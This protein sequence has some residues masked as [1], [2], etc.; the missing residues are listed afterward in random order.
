M[1][2]NTHKSREFQEQH[3]V[4]ALN[5]AGPLV[6]TTFEGL[7]TQTCAGLIAALRALAVGSSYGATIH[8]ADREF[9]IKNLIEE[10]KWQMA[11]NGEANAPITDADIVAAIAAA[12]ANADVDFRNIIFTDLATLNGYARRESLTGNRF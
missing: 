11:V 1:N 7:G 5:V 3:A 6:R 9:L 2:A 8:G 12:G 10:L 4:A